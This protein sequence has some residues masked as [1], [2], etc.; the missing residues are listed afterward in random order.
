VE[1]FIIRAELMIKTIVHDR[2]MTGRSE[3]RKIPDRF[4]SIAA[5]GHWNT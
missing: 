2:A 4:V 5:Y 1:D 3:G